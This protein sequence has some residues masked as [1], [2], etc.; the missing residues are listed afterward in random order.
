[1]R[2]LFVSSGNAKDGISPIVLSQGQSLIREGINVEYFAIK[3]KGV[4]AYFRHIFILRKFL[5]KNKFDIIHAHYSLTA[6][7]AT[8]AGSSPLIVSLMGSDVLSN[9]F[10]RRLIKSF[11]KRFWDRTIV[12]SLYMHQY[13]GFKEIEIIPNGVDIKKINFLD[14]KSCQEKLGWDNSNSHLIFAADPSRRE[15]NFAMVKKSVKLLQSFKNTV[16]HILKDVSQ[17]DIPLYMNAADVLILSS[18][19]EGSPNVIKE[20]MACNCPI[21]TTNVGDVKWVLGNTAGC[22]IS[23]F[24]PKCFAEMIKFAIDFRDKHGQTR[25][26]E[27]IIEL[28]LDTETVAAKII[29]VYNKVLNC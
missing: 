7:V 3:G 4:L 24:S 6:Y 13:L 9:S 15:K 28:G 29:E 18:F 12:K 20:A 2:I 16:V 26:R 23:S 5:K 27:R 11:H 19:Y 14:K 25:G 1:M 8:L 17:E 21:V 22:F 10:A